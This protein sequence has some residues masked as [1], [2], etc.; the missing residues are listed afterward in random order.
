MSTELTH[1]NCSAHQISLKNRESMEISGVTDVISFDEQSI[2]LSTLCGN[3]V[4]DGLSLHIH[5]LT[6]EQGVVTL[7]GK[8]DSVT[9][10]EK[11]TAETEGKRG[12][13]GKIFR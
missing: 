8:I 1:G 11:A 3:M 12:F 7:D 5:V 10:Y 2:V 9:Y 6:L 13:F 4:I